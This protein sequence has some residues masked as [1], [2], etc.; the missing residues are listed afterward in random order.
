MTSTIGEILPVAAQRFGART[1]LLVG[2]H[3]F[4]FDDLQ[5]LSDRAANG[6]V[7]AGRVALYRPNC[8]EWL[9]AYYGIAKTGAVLIPVNVMLTPDEVRYVV[10][11]SDTRAVIASAD[12][13]EPLLDLRGTGNLQDVVLWGAEIPPGATAFA[14]WLSQGRPEFSPVQRDGGDLAA[15]C[16]T[17]GTTGHPKGAMQPHRAVIGAAVGTAVM[18]ARGPDDRVINSLPLPHVYGS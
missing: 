18:A 5:A 16:Y 4:S 15:V 10:E 14:N 12:K 17:S 7:D 8:W 2:D 9:V 3:S 13:G 1:A 6:L 11:D